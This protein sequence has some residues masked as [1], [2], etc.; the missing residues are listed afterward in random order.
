MLM[1][2]KKQNKKVVALF[3]A[4]DAPSN[5]GLRGNNLMLIFLLISP[6]SP[7]AIVKMNYSVNWDFRG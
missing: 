1:E 6:L 4:T 3:G 2:T 7:S 5:E